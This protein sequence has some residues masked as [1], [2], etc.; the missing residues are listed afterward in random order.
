MPPSAARRRA[1]IYA[2]GTEDEIEQQLTEAFELCRR[3]HQDVVGVVRE[4]PGGTSGY[5]DAHRML[6]RGECDLIAV[7]STTNLPDLI[8]SATG[9]LTPFRPPLPAPRDPR[10]RRIRPTPRGD[11][12]A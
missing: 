2:R 3:R 9:D 6:R 12:G 10:S 8:E 1:L 11:A 5:H 7:A 4:R